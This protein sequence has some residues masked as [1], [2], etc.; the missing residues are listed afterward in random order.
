MIQVNF[1]GELADLAKSIGLLSTDGLLDTSW[2]GDPFGR[3]Q[4]VLSNAEQRAALLRLLD[5]ALPPRTGLD[6][7]PGE[8]WHPLL[9]ANDY[10]NVYVT[11]RNGSKG[12]VIGFAGDFGRDRIGPA[13]ERQLSA[14][15]SASMPII[16]A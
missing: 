6:I 7:P 2:F 14:S 16:C 11:V 3:L 5:S 4:T 15:I 13:P 12:A 10:G 9:T 8:K 1:S